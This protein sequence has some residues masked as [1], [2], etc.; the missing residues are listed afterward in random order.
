MKYLIIYILNITDYSLTLYLTGL[1]GIECEVNPLMRYALSTPGVFAAVKLILLPLL[2]IWMWRR[3]K[4]D[5][6]LVVLGMFIVVVLLNATQ[7][8]GIYNY[9]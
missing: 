9:T 1:Y 6:A 7:A 2:L 5:A 8:L 4:D 3:K